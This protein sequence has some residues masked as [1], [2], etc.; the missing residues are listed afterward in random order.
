MISPIV[1]QIIIHYCVMADD[2]R[3]GDHLDKKGIAG[4]KP[5]K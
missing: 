3:D 5:S 4:D 1:L 2:F